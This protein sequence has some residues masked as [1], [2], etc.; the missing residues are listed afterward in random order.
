[1]AIW[2]HQITTDFLNEQKKNTCI[3]NMDI[4][5]TEIGDNFIKAKMPVSSK[6]VQPYRMLH[7]GATCVLAETLGSVGSNLVLDTSKHVAVGQTISANHLRPVMEGGFVE[8]T[9]EPIHIGAKSHI[10][11]IKVYDQKENLICLS[12]LTNAV[13][14]K[15]N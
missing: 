10:W 4:E 15:P 3:D 2:F 7:G 12:T 5:Y 9:A 8:G 13:I 6:N 1:M 11:Q 14:D